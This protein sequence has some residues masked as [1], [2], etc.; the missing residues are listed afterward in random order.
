MKYFLFTLFLSS[1]S[2]AGRTQGGYANLN[3]QAYSNSDM[4]FGFGITMSGGGILKKN[5]KTQ[6]QGMTLGLGAGFMMFNDGANPYIPFF[7]EMGYLH[8]EKKIAPYVN[9]RT[10][11]GIY[12]GEVDFIENNVSVKG[13][14]FGDFRLGAA[15]K[16]AKMMR[17]TPYAGLT[18]FHFRQV[19]SGKT[20]R[21][22]NK[23][24]PTLGIALIFGK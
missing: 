2:L 6:R 19:E 16:V 3:F 5:G 17:A 23:A 8:K 24:L 15:F 9:V 18:I 12:D 1:L 20:I 4:P 7:L 13:G 14:F 22:F 10:G 11:Y 21:T